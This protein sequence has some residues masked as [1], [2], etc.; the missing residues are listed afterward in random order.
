[1]NSESFSS[2][3]FSYPQS[4]L[5]NNSKQVY[6]LEGSCIV[7]NFVVE[8]PSK[9]SSSA[10]TCKFTS[11]S[12][13]EYII[14]SETNK[15][16]LDAERRGDCRPIEKGPNTF[17]ISN[18]SYYW[19]VLST[20]I[21]PD[22]ETV[23]V[24]TSFDYDLKK[25]AY[26]LTE[27]GNPQKQCTFSSETQKECQVATGVFLQSQRKHVLTLLT[28]SP[29]T[30]PYTVTATTT[31]AVGI[32]VIVFGIVEFYVGFLFIVLGIVVCCVYYKYVF[33]TNYRI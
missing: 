4:V 8:N 23:Y 10:K 21:S 28:E 1:M 16:I 15:T 31:N 6:L 32:A 13:S 2:K 18:S 27:L 17:H 22:S 7:F 29:D 26:N 14:D 19:Y 30:G 11:L 12:N 20:L 33:N 9:F 24:L 3:E 25:L 5:I